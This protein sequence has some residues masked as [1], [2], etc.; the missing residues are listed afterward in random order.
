M[1][2]FWNKSGALLSE[3]LP[4]GTVMSSPYYGSIIEQF[5]CAT[6]EKCGGK[7]VLLLH[8]NALDHKCNIVQAALRKAGFVESNDPVYSPDLASC[9]SYLFSNSNKLVHGK[10]FSLDDE[11]IDTV[12]EYLNK[13]N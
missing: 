7:V 4:G 2:I 8:T 6:M 10:S 11:K 5:P 9:N 13:V 3:Y 12:E 1:V